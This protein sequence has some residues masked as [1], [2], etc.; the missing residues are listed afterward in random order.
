MSILPSGDQSSYGVALVETAVRHLVK[1]PGLS[2]EEVVKRARVLGSYMDD[3][4]K[5]CNP[6][7]NPASYRHCQVAA[8]PAVN[9]LLS[10]IQMSSKIETRTGALI[11]LACMC[12]DN[13]ANAS[14][15]VTSEL[16]GPMLDRT[17]RPIT[18]IKE[19]EE[20]LALLQFLQATCAVA[21]EAP[22][23]VPVLPKVVDL[24]TGTN[25]G[26]P[27]CPAVRSTALEVLVSCALSHHRRAQLVSLLPSSVL[28]MLVQYAE[29]HAAEMLF[30]LGLLFANLS[31]LPLSLS[32]QGQHAN[33][34]K[35]DV[36]KVCATGRNGRIIEMEGSGQALQVHLDNGDIFWYRDDQLMF[37]EDICS[38][39]VNADAQMFWDQT[40]FFS[41]LLAC[42]Q[43][44]LNSESWPP[45][46]G[47]FH[48]KWK[49]AGTYS[50][51][52]KAGLAG[53]LHGAVNP[54]ILLVERR[55]GDENLMPDADAVRAARLAVGA[56]L[57][58]AKE[59]SSLSQMRL[60]QNLRASLARMQDEEPAA[61]DLLKI[62]A[63]I[64]S[65]T[66]PHPQL[67]ATSVELVTRPW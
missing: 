63:N 27:A 17:L 59:D 33:P 21:P 42:L 28:Q 66:L 39:T 67:D 37:G 44:S 19:Q 25:G 55:L 56:L 34:H 14:D 54:L 20:S 61:N 49:L 12:F 36:V 51:L 50:R 9:G 5:C 11:A 22:A 2:A 64:P 45:Q 26:H 60:S 41:D 43:A 40:G 35:G 23:L 18:E 6:R 7:D 10:L 3:V 38:M 47:I 57:E 1:A 53:Q 52:A 62:L 48:A 16:F 4:V 31:D 29:G 46:S 15:A 65:Q 58:L 8:R 24:L 32:G 13:L 30:P